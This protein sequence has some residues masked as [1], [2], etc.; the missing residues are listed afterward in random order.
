MYNNTN[1]LTMN[2]NDLKSLVK[3]YFNLTE[4]SAVKQ[5]F[6]EATL[7]D[8]T[9]KIYW[10]GDL[11]VGTKVYLLDAEGNQIPAPE[12]SHT[13]EDGKNIVLG[14]EG[15]ILEVAEAA[16]EEMIEQQ[17]I[18]PATGVPIDTPVTFEE[19][20]AAPVMVEDIVKAVVEAVQ[21]EMGK[22]MDRMSAV[23]TKVETFS[24]AP[25]SEKTLPGSVKKAST[26]AVE[27]LQKDR[28]ERVLKSVKINRN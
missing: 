19:E 2:V 14:T 8:G 24:A 21:D 20:V 15:E 9:T 25:A 23:E 5:E 27:P 22:Y 7:A 16:R 18:D 11:A 4:A 26:P 6:A 28:F 1:R 13:L 10:D 17:N 12:G 3:S